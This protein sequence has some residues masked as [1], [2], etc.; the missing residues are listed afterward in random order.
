E[1]QA[2]ESGLVQ[3]R[4]RAWARAH[5]GLCDPSEVADR[6]R[7]PSARLWERR[8][9]DPDFLHLS[10][11]LGTVGWQPPLANTYGARPPEVT[12][13]VANYSSLERAPVLVD[14]SNGGVVGIAG[15]RGAALALARS[16]LCQAAVHHGPADM[17]VMVLTEPAQTAVWDWAKWLP[18]TRDGGA[19]GATRTLAGQAEQAEE[20]LRGLLE[21]G[22]KRRDRRFEEHREGPVLLM[23]VD[24]VGVTEGKNAPARAAL[25]GEAGP[26]A[27]IVLAPSPERLPAM[28]T[29]V[30][31]MLD[32]QGM[33]NLT[34][35]RLGQRVEELLVGGISV[36][37]AR[38]CALA[39]ARFEDPEAVAPG[40]SLPSRVDLPS[41]F[42]ED[43][44]DPETLAG[45]WR[46]DGQDPGLAAPIGVAEDGILTLDIV[47]DGPHGLVG[48]TTGSGKSE[49]LRGLVAGLAL[50]ISPDYLNFVLID[51][52][53]GSAFD[54]CARLPHT[55][56]LVTDLDAELGERALRCLEAELRY[57]ERVLREAGADDL[58]AYLR[59]PAAARTP[60]PRLMVIIDEFATMAAELPEFMEALVGIAQRGRGLGCTSCWPRSGPPA[61]SRTT[62]APTPTCAS[63]CGSK[64][65]ATRWM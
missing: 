61:R 13:V 18:H 40:S 47:R 33:A 34:E 46:T 64:T 44:F 19:G 4:D 6:A 62:S 63:R 57:R 27:G 58:R 15:E 9:H 3:E 8:L 2:F 16:L 5:D 28:C 22:R 50:R 23:V 56:G 25:R 49:L 32:A 29:T 31:E 17:R 52:K 54:E 53:G 30:I 38:S 26:V 21:T 20:L 45:Q 39:L 51:Y 37:T 48:G 59:Q 36:E 14:L 42:V 24:A 65:T 11:G 12:E 7:A 55:V 35:P 43:V 60:L 1:L 41:L 10:A